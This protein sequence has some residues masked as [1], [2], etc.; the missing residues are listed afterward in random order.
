MVFF[1]PTRGGDPAFSRVLAELLGFAPPCADAEVSPLAHFGVSTPVLVAVS[2]APRMGDV[3]GA[4]GDDEPSAGVGGSLGDLPAVRAAFHSLTGLS[5][6]PSNQRRGKHNARKRAEKEAR[7]SRFCGCHRPAT[8][9]TAACGASPA[10]VILMANAAAAA[11][12]TAT[13]AAVAT[14]LLCRRRCRHA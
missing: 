1:G 6:H 13:T 2:R 3:A 10:I 12:V 5:P 4:P 11:I 9:T 7:T 8:T 14:D